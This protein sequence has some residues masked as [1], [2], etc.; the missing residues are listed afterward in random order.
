MIC[1]YCQHE[2]ELIQIELPADVVI[3]GKE[4]QVEEI[5]RLDKRRQYLVDGC[6]PS[7]KAVPVVILREKS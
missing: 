2:T 3:G 7:T 6:L 1:P 4:Y 5:Q